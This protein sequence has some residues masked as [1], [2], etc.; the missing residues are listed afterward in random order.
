MIVVVVVVVSYVVVVV[1][2]VVVRRDRG[3]VV[4]R[5]RGRGCGRVVRRGCG[6]GRGRG[7]GRG[8]LNTTRFLNLAVKHPAPPRESTK[9]A[10]RE[11]LRFFACVFL[12]IVTST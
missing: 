10:C 4:R 5:D 6:R 1:V 12:K 8:Y 2:V 7:R 11:A 9:P 3:R